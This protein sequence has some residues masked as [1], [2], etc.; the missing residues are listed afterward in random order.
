MWDQIL[1]GLR[2]KLFMTILL[3]VIYP[4]AMTNLSA[5]SGNLLSLAN[6]EPGKLQ[7]QTA[8]APLL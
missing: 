4:L 8:Q 1:P 6:C 7:V 3:G 2:I 5:V